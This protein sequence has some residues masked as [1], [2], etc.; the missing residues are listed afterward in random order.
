MRPA[1][2]V[3]ILALASC[4]GDSGTAATTVAPGGDTTTST[5]GGTTTLASRDHGR[6][7]CRDGD[8]GHDGTRDHSGPSRRLNPG[9]GDDGRHQMVGDRRWPSLATCTMN[10]RR[11]LT[12]G[13]PAGGGPIRSSWCTTRWPTM[14]FFPGRT[15][16][17]GGGLDRWGPSRSGSGG[18]D[19]V[20]FILMVLVLR[21]RRRQHGHRDDR[22]PPGRRRRSCRFS[23]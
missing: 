17:L 22:D 4:G 13:S 19:C 12:G 5:G 16:P 14:I 18:T 10:W 9:G 3:L 23:T 6:R 15:I 8:H 20:D 2:F 7:H 1:G 11:S 21:P